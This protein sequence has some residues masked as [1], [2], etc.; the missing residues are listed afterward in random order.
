MNKFNLEEQE[1]K[2]LIGLLYNHIS[3]G[4]TLEVLGELKEEGIDRLNL[5]RGI[6]G[7]LLKKFELDKSLSQENYLLLG[8][9]DFIEESSLEKWS[10]DDNNKHLQ[11][12]AKYFLKKHYGK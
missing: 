6:F 7:K 3:F 1:E 5:L 11:N 8:M 12:R 10:E 2:A 9:N 4:T